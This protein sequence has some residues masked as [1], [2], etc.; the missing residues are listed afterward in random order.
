MVFQPKVSL[1]I[2]TYN[3]GAVLCDTVRMALAQ[4]YADFEVIVVD[5]TAQLETLVREY[6]DSVRD[7]IHYIHLDTPNLPG[8]RNAGVRAATGE[9]VLFIDDDVII[10]PDYMERHVRHFQDPD[11]GAVMGATLGREQT[12]AETYLDNVKGLFGFEG[13]PEG[14][15]VKVGWVLGGNTSYRRAA[16]LNVGMSDERFSGSGWCEDA[17]LAV[18]V[19]ASGHDLLFDSNIRMIHLAIPSGGC[20]NRAMISPE[21]KRRER[22]SHEVYFRI[23][24]RRIFGWRA[25]FRA[26]LFAY[27]YYVLNRTLA[28]TNAIGVLANTCFYVRSIMRSSLYVLRKHGVSGVVAPDVIAGAHR[29][30]S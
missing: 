24:N 14:G 5:Q 26:I 18:R 29:G 6:L 16:I 13:Q 12:S 20:E 22:V 1:I 4:T 28:R 21:A 11:V 9:I 8:A 15:V 17:D 23:K 27:R 10:E 19:R 25:T 7:R 30:I 3:R 2:P